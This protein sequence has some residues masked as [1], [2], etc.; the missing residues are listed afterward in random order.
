MLRTALFVTAEAAEEAFYEAIERGD[1]DA[2]MALWVEDDEAVCVHPGGQR[3]VGVPAIRAGWE[4]VLR[5]GGMHVRPTEIHAVQSGTLAVRNVVEQVVVSGRMGTEVVKVIATNVFVKGPI[6]W[7]MAM[8]VA[9]PAS[10]DEQAGTAHEMSG[11]L[12]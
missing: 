7:R 12:H 8:H 9:T 5:H 1:L 4:E 3:L 10:V 6:G 2:L 11:M